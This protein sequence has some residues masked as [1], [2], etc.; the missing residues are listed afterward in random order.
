MKPKRNRVMCPDC[1]RAKMLF[2]S[3]AK[4]NNFIKWNGPDI[5]THGGVLRPYYCPSCCGWH[6]SSKPYI[7]QYGHRTEELIGAYE[8]IK[9]AVTV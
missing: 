2:E 4:A 8:R 1:G 5:N 9:N 6:I 7:E 3:E